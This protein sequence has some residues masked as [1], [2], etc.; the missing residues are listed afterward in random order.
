MKLLIVEDETELNSDICEYLGNQ[1]Y[2]VRG[3]HSKFDAEDALLDSEYAL[4]VLDVNLPD[5]SGLELLEWL[6]LERMG[7]GVLIL[8][9]RDSLDDKL[10]GLDI[11]ADDYLTKPFHYAE[12]SS[13]VKA[14]LRRK[15][16][17]GQRLIT[18]GE[19]ELDP[20]KKAA[21]LAG[22]LLTLTAKQY[23][24]LELFVTNPGKVL[25]KESIAA[26]LWN[27]DPDAYGDFAFIYTHI[28]NVRQKI[29]AAG[30]ADYLQ[31]VYGSGY[32][33]IDPD[34]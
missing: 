21:S 33:F 10:A 22:N 7:S 27:D 29:K 30:G 19:L 25:T 20:E 34:A 9:A 3:V 24:I 28:K 4:V 18:I 12:L 31:S 26:R 16:F 32:R 2:S 23:E 1:G 6:K 17:D 8:S 5:G 13:R 11:G 15:K 14:I